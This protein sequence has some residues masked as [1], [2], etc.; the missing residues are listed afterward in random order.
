M[1]LIAVRTWAPIVFKS[2]GT[3]RLIG[4]AL[5]ILQGA[6]KFKAKDAAINALFMELA[7][8]FAPVGAEISAMHV[9]SEDN[10]LADTLSRLDEGAKLPL[11]VLRSFIV[12]FAAIASVLSGMVLRRRGGCERECGRVSRARR[13]C[14]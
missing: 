8:L 3:L 12:S 5:G 2:R 1:L 4:D 14:S 7:L 11:I 10:K 13:S 9:W 6:V